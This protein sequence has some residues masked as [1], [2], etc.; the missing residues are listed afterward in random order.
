EDLCRVVSEDFPELLDVDSVALCLE[1]EI[2]PPGG[3]ATILMHGYVGHLL[4]RRRALLRENVKGDP[5]LFGEAA[6]SVRSDA[7]VRLEPGEGY[8]TGLL[9][10][11]SRYPDA[12]HANQGADLLMFL[13]QVLEW[14]LGRWLT[15]PG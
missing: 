8:P 2:P 12:F 5:I 4:G 6:A 13:A 7:L 1:T 15:A 9:A 3:P 11:G 10:L 14:S